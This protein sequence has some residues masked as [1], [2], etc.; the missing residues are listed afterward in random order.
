MVTQNR[1]K[2]W[3]IKITKGLRK[4]LKPVLLID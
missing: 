4:D 3:K 2:F 1:R